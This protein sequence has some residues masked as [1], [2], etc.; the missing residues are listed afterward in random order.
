M[1]DELRPYAAKYALSDAIGSLF[2]AAALTCPTAF[3]P[4]IFLRSDNIIAGLLRVNSTVALSLGDIQ[5]GAVIFIAFIISHFA[6]I[7]L[8]LSYYRA[9]WLTGFVE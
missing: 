5:L 1:K 2:F 3:I 6:A 4:D 7:P 9:K 8:S